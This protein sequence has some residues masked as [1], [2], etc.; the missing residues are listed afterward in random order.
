[1]Q[2]LLIFALLC[3]LFIFSIARRGPGK[4]ITPPVK[5]PPVK[6]PPVKL[7][8][9]PVM[10]TCYFIADP[11]AKTL[12]NVYFEA[13]GIGDWI[14][15]KGPHMTISYRGQKMPGNRWVGI[16][17]WFARIG[18]FTVRSKGN[19]ITVDGHLHPLNKPNKVAMGATSVTW[20]NKSVQLRT[21]GEEADFQFFGTFWNLNI[22]STRD[23]SKIKGLCMKQFLPSKAFP[24]PKPAAVI[25]TP[26][27]SCPKR[28]QYVTWCKKH[29]KT[30]HAIDRCVFDRCAGTGKALENEIIKREDKERQKT[31]QKLPKVQQKVIKLLKK[32]ARRLQRKSNELQ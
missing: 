25:M 10:R 24:H 9:K 15:Y 29:N 14:A 8:P 4:E 16:V 31:V 18:D 20:N 26:A 21:R 1:M 17:E 5:I 6:L 28:T 13:Q 12:T 19:Q 7:P 27:A 2:K 23:P 22:R 30:Q 11:H 32:S 3:A